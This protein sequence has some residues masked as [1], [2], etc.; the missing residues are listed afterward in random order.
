MEDQSSD[1]LVG[2]CV[3]NINTGCLAI[4]IDKSDLARNSAKD[5]FA[6]MGRGADE[7]GICVLKCKKSVCR[8]LR[9][10]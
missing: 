2:Q 9:A 1:R 3:I 7:L 4:E 8:H 5:G 6:Q 10:G